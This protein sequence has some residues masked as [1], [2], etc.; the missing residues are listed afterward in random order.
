[1][2]RTLTIMILLGMLLSAF[3]I[4]ALAVEGPI[5]PLVPPPS[6]E[7][8]EMVNE[9]PSLWFVE[10][11]SPPTAD[12]GSLVFTQR[13]K[14]NFRAAASRAG[15]EFSERYAFDTL[16]NGL[17]IKINPVDLAKLARIP[18]VAALYP[19]ESISLPEASV[20]SSPELYTAIQM[21]GADIAQSEL[22]YTGAGVKVAVMDTGIDYDHPDL[23]GC[24][25]PGCRV[26]YGWD[27][28]GDAFSA[29]VNDTRVPDPDPDDCGGHGTHVAGI[30]GANGTVV[31]VAPDVTFGAYRVF[32]CS[33]STWADIMIEAMEMALA[34]GMD[35]L[36]MSIGSAFTWPQYPTATAS[37]RLVNKGMVVVASIGNSGANGVYSAGAPGLGKKVIGVA[38][39][40]NTHNTFP[41][42]EIDGTD[43]G[44]NP[45]S[46]S[47]PVP[48]AGTHEILYVGQACNADLP[49]LANPAGKVALI[50]RGTCSFNEKATNAINAGAIAVV[51][52]NNASGNF[53]G[54]LGS[55]IGDGSVP[56]VSISLQDGLFIRAQAAPVFITWTNRLAVFADPSGG[57]IASSSS[58]GLAPDLSLKPDIGAPGGNIY[59]TYPLELGGYA[60]L[61][62]TSMASPHVAGA[63]ALLLQAKPHTPSQVVRDILQ[64]SADPKNWWGNPGLGF[65][66]NV[67]RQG[68]GLV[69]IDDA[70]LATTK[71]TPGKIAAGESEAGP[72]VQ[73]LTLENKGAMDVTYDLAY[74]NALST[75]GVITPSFFLS[76]ASVAFDA[77]SVMVPAGGTATV[78]ATI[79]PA[80]GPTFGQYGGYLVFTPQGGGQVYRVPFAGFVGDYQSIGVLAN[81]FGLPWLIG[82]PTFSMVGSD[83]PDFWVHFDH[84]PEKF[85]MEVFSAKGKAWHRAYD[86]EFLPRNSTSTSIFAFP[87]DGY[88]FNGNKV[89][90]VPDGEY[91]VIISVLKA[92]GDSNN[93]AHWETWTSPNFVIDRP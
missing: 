63:A 5:E 40:N 79:N 2:K 18:G 47:G 89:N 92:N 4:P 20:G 12:G 73:M 29:G 90:M 43:V 64:N 22:G 8:G 21:T 27:L 85:R 37:D 26:A 76:N 62:G 10:F 11:S 38:S 70:I 36:N 42:F 66:D 81:A 88:T 93:P 44:Y 60:T 86:E 48:T 67:H 72:F 69:D 55:Q 3:T 6:A 80:T 19:V 59:S 82:G 41:V 49:L 87:F 50:N 33:G 78:M 35:I 57:L 16:W 54:T 74:V 45:M 39:F 91:Y 17:S 51:I 58:Y 84:Q 46:Y 32:G 28:V 14:A 31:G 25:G 77:P 9:T 24:F 52:H 61:G 71:I 34:D 23:G 65:L 13:E 30:V 7:T 75:G 56:V 53:S 68:A 1:M 15:L 83:I